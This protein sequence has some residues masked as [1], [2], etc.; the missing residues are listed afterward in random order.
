MKSERIDM[1]GVNYLYKVENFYLAGQPSLDSWQE[2]KDLG[3]KKVFNI[4]SQ[5]EVDDSEQIKV[6]ENL[7]IEYTFH[8]IMGIN[9]LDKE[10]CLKLNEFVNDSDQILVHC[11]SANRV[12]AWFAFYL[13]KHKNFNFEQAI[14]LSMSAGLTNNA[15]IGQISD[16]LDN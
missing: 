11:A 5:G 15:L 10:Q 13:V 2:F 12:A 4:R 6:L 14:E 8:P 16:I 3:I 7:G 9:G 1:V